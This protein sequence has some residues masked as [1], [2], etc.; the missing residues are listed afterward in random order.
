VQR[1]FRLVVVAV[2]IALAPACM[3]QEGVF[4]DA[5]KDTGAGSEDAGRDGV[6]DAGRDAGHDGRA[7]DA[8][9]DSRADAG[10]DAVADAGLDGGMVEAPV[11]AP[12]EARA[13]GPREGAIDAPGSPDLLPADRA[14][15]LVR[16]RFTGK[17]VTV[18]GT[19]L[20]LA[21]STVQ[22]M[23]AITG[24]LAYDLD[25]IDNEATDTTRG[26]FQHNG[27]S[28]FTFALLGHTVTG[29][30]FAKVETTAGDTFRFRDGPQTL[31]PVVRVMK[32]DGADAPM[33]SLIIAITG[34]PSLLPSDA[35]PDPFP[36]ITIATT[37]HTFSLSDAGGTLL[38][39]LDMLG[40]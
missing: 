30:G 28:E 2:A 11:D 9:T 10:Q 29:S 19:S 22:N 6:A 27:T 25:V 14:A 3:V 26:V 18:T 1:W 21:A 39:Q 8:A 17:A 20:G 31:D 36:A 33:V 38:M 13:D 16:L 24:T 5:R 15:R 35:L 34:G 32:L 4:P 7:T 23:P 40:P 12:A 37:P